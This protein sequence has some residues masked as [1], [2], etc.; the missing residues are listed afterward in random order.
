MGKNQKE[1]ELFSE[2]IPRVKG[3]VKL[4]IEAE[5]QEPIDPQICEM[6]VTTAASVRS[7]LIDR[8]REDPAALALYIAVE[9]DLSGEP[10]ELIAMQIGQLQ[11]MTKERG[12]H[13]NP[14]E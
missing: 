8:I 6:R 4:F 12:D 11:E 9:S 2:V 10:E 14:T 5:S 1:P 3:L 7:Y 13:A